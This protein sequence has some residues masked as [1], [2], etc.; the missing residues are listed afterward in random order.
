M[1]VRVPWIPAAA[2]IGGLVGAAVDRLPMGVF[3]RG[4]AATVLAW[5]LCLAIAAMGFRFVSPFASENGAGLLSSRTLLTALILAGVAGGL[6]RYAGLGF[7]LGYRTVILGMVGGAA[8][9]VHGLLAS[10]S[11]AIDEG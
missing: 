3:A 10:A 8:G 5:V 9:A 7:D 2:V 4:I 1:W 6:A 11:E